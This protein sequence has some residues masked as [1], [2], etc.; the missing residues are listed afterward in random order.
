FA[1]C[2]LKIWAPSAAQATELV[3]SNR[4]VIPMS[5]RT[6]SSLPP[7]ARWLWEPG[8]SVKP[9]H[10]RR[11]RSEGAA[12]CARCVA[13]HRIDWQGEAERRAALLHAGGPQA[14]AMVLDDA[15]ADRQAEPQAARLGGD[16]RGEERVLHR[17]GDTAA[18][19]AHRYLDRVAAA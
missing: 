1:H 10:A 5:G 7:P 11:C 8:R 19:V 13:A 2:A 3:T 15:A 18:A 14:A 17:G 12:Y 6:I 16:E 4:A 9:R